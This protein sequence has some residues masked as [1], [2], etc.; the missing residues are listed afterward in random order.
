MD[1]GQRG[2]GEVASRAGQNVLEEETPDTSGI[3]NA[4]TYSDPMLDADA[5]IKEVQDALGHDS[6]S[7][8]MHYLHRRQDAAQRGQ[9]KLAKRRSRVQPE[10]KVHKGGK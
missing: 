4:E 5:N 1:Q 9:E 2:A 8:T 6:L 7:S 3:S 10:L